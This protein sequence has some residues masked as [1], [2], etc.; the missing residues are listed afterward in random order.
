MNDVLKEILNITGIEKLNPVQEK[1]VKAGLLDGKNI[2][3]ASPTASGK[4]IV[5]EIAI[6]NHFRKGGKCVYLAPLKALASEK[7]SDMKKKYVKLGLRVAVSTSDQDSADEWLGAY[8][9]IILT[10]EKMDSAIRHNSSWVE[11]LTLVIVDE[12]HMLGDLSRGPTLEVVL[13]MLKENT[14]AQIVAL[15]ATISNS[16]EISDW[17]KAKEVKSDYRP[18]ALHKGVVYPNEEG[19]FINFPETKRNYTLSGGHLETAVADDTLERSKQILIFYSSRR[20]TEAAVSKFYKIMQK[21]MNESGRKELQKAAKE[22]LNALPASTKQCEKLAEAVK[23]GVAFHHAGL[24]SGQRTIIENLFR[25]GKLKILTATPTLA[26]GINLPAW[27]VLVRDVYRYSSGYASEYIPNLE[28]QQYC[29]RAGRPQY[30]TE[31]EAIIV[32][33]SEADSQRITDRYIYDE[34]EPIESKLSS[35]AA[36]RMHT[37]SLIAMQHARSVED[38]KKFFSKTFFGHQIQDAK[39]IKSIVEKALY[40]L[41][42]WNF[43]QRAGV[44]KNYS[45]FKP[46]YA[47]T[48]DSE[49]IATPLGKRVAQLYI[50]PLSAVNII[51]HLKSH[52][53][54]AYLIAISLCGEMPRVRVKK[55]EIE[56]L[57]DTLASANLEEAPDVWDVDYES[58]IAAVKSAMIL[59][60]WMDERG[61]DF[62]LNKYSMPPGELYGRTSNA[63]WLLYA[64]SEIALILNRKPEA[65]EWRKLQLRVKHGVRED[66]LRLVEI[67]GIGRA[68]ARKLWKAGIRSRADIRNTS[69][70]AL[71]KI[72]GPKI[73]K[74]IKNDAILKKMRE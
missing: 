54:F 66:L 33:R 16:S 24:V 61:E 27:R 5:A 14:K 10:N 12:V 40:Q 55:D 17:L 13:T 63:E 56:E 68:R 26:F 15:S 35:E 51:R 4:T 44:T 30:D 49:I 65:N 19:F 72:L 31:G 36:M 20:N 1:A 37:L 42:E 11:K 21:R 41:E 29:G 8:D 47:I 3:V 7:Y 45:N 57:S 32:A 25:E 59:Q 9:V 46:A 71:S 70:V 23:N 34:P 2:V 38:V 67:R 39:K 50:D 64:G 6:L 28:V 69:D 18:V 74:S 52:D 53:N 58:Y 73:T 48:D 62:I 60:D 43:V 22:I